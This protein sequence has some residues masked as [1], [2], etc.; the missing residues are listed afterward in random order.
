MNPTIKFVSET[1][2][3]LITEPLESVE[4][5]SGSRGYRAS[6]KVSVN[7]HRLQVGVNAVIIGSK[8]KGK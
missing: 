4:F 3:T 8:P 7:G 6:F 5:K 2:E 1:G